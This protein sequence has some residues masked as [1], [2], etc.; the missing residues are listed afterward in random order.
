MC[1]KLL[2][3]LVAHKALVMVLI[4]KRGHLLAKFN[5]MDYGLGVG[6]NIEDK[7]FLTLKLSKLIYYV[8]E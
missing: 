5:V 3:E 1:A 8:L 6:G 2:L 7:L 4:K